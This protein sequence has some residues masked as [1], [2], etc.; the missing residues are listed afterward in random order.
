MR[1]LPALLLLTGFIPVG[2]AGAEQARAA[3]GP[4]ALDGLPL[5]EVFPKAGAAAANGDPATPLVVLLTGDGGWAAI[6]KAISAAL[7][8]RGI[9]VVGVNSLRFYWTARSADEAAADVARV[10]EHYSLALSKSR[11]VLI[12]YSFGADVVPFVANR[13]PAHPRS[14]LDQVVLIGP[15]QLATFEVKFREWIPGL[16]PKG[17]PLAPE[18]AKLD[19]GKILCL[20]GADETRSSCPALAAAG[21][22]TEKIGTGHH[23]G[24]EYDEI[25]RQIL[26]FLQP[27]D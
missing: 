1:L 6:D 22:R 13:L 15:S 9:P 11:V 4:E 10:I 2:R 25:S 18:L 21:A 19:A 8:E 5:T 3:A 16:T 7:V 20:Y 26:A 17:E 14:M 27:G 24:G 23:L 12:G